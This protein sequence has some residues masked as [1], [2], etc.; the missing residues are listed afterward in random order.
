[1]YVQNWESGW[2]PL[3]LERGHCKTFLCHW[4]WGHE[5]NN[6]FKWQVL[7]FTI[8]GLVFFGYN[9][10]ICQWA[11]SGDKNILIFL[12]PKFHNNGHQYWKP[13]HS[14][15]LNTG[16]NF[17]LCVV[18]SHWGVRQPN[19]FIEHKAKHCKAMSSILQITKYQHYTMLAS[20]ELLNFKTSTF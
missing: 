3:L 10:K 20:V 9:L 2:V 11:S 12:D 14:F 15:K 4:W 18:N 16:G 1:M 5:L 17:K 13:Q 6:Y 7:L 19:P 8:L